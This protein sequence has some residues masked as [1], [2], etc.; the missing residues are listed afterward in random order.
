MTLP[1]PSCR[2]RRSSRRTPTPLCGQFV[3]FGI[4]LH[5]GKDLAADDV[6]RTFRRIT[7]PKKPL[8]GATLA[9]V[10]IAGIK[11]LDK[12]TLRIPCH[13]PFVALA[14]VRAGLRISNRPVGFDPKKPVGTGPF[15]FQSF[16]P[17]QQSTFVQILTTGNLV[18]RTSTRW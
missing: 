13:T 10:N 9:A 7:D 2:W 14:D 3:S 4:Q 5:N 17:G 11:K 18:F 1:T 8:T 15:K 12:R 16:T 6:I